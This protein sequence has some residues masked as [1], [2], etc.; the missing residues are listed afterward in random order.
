MQFRAVSHLVN[1]PAESLDQ[2]LSA[3]MLKDQFRLR[4]QRQQLD[5]DASGGKDVT[6]RLE[7]WESQLQKS[8]ELRAFRR[9][10]MPAIGLDTELPVAMRGDEIASVIRDHQVVVISGETG[11]GKSTQLPLICMQLGLGVGGFVGHTQPRRI[12]ARGVASRIAESVGSR[13]GETVGYKIRFGDQTSPGTL[14]KVMTDGILLAETAS[15]RFLNAYEAII[16]DEA[17][18]RS[19]NIDFLLCYIK[20]LLPQRPDLKLLITSA[21]IDTGKFAEHFTIDSGQPV[22]V[23]HVEGRT[24]PVDLE[25]RPVGIDQDGNEV[26]EDLESATISAIMD[27]AARDRGDMLVF[28]PTEQS[29]RSLAKKLRSRSL[30]RDGAR[31]TDILPL[32]ARLS[33]EQQNAIF[34]PGAARRI[35]LATNV[36]ESSITVPRIRYVV[37]QGLA[38]ISRYAPRS[39][40]QRLPIESV[41]QA[42]ADQRAGRCGRIGPGICV[43]LFAEDDFNGR[44]KFT[45]PEIRRTNLASVILQTKALRLGAIEDFPFIEAPG[46]E[47]IRDGYRTLH[48]I[49]AVDHARELTSLGKK[50]SR[51]PVDPR[52]GRMLYAAHDNGCLEEVLVIAS[53]LEVQDPRVRPAEQQAAADTAHSQFQ[54]EDSDFLAYLNLWD[55]LHQRREDLSRGKFRKACAQNFLSYMLVQQWFDVHRQLKSMCCDGRTQIRSDRENNAAI[56]Q[57]LLTGLLSG[58]AMQTDRHEYTGAGGIKFLLWPGSGLVKAQAAKKKNTRGDNQ[59]AL[60]KWVLV[61]EVVET[62]RRFGR[63]VARIDPAWIEPLAQHLVKRNYSEPHWSKKRQSAL[64]WEK[65]SLFGLPIVARRPV[66]YGN[67]DPDLSRQLLIEEGLAGNQMKKDPPFL[68]HN[69]G[70]LE[71]IQSLAAKT[72][73]REWII[74]PYRVVHFY[75]DR[76]PAEVFDG[77]ELSGALKRDPTL[78]ARLRFTIDDLLPDEDEDQ[79]VSPDEFPDQMAIGDLQL[80]VEYKF[81]PGADDDGVSV[82]VPLE[83]VAQIHDN[84]L[85][86]SVP[87]LLEQRIVAVIRSLPKA[88][89][90]NLVPAPE[91]AA[92]VAREIEFGRG[93]FWQVVAEGLSRHAGQPVTP[94]MFRRDKLDDALKLNIQVCDDKGEVI[95]QARSI[96]ELKSLLPDSA[97]HT[98]VA[99]VVDHGWHQDGLTNWAWDELPSQV[100]VRRGVADVPLF[101]TLVDKD[102]SVD[103]RLY[104]NR[105]LSR[106]MSRQGLATM[107]RLA[108]RKVIKSQVNWLPDL[109]RLAMIAS[110]L[111]GTQGSLKTALAQ[112]ISLVAFVESGRPVTTREE[113]E[114]RQKNAVERVGMATQKIAPWLTRFLENYQACDVQLESLPARFAHAENDIQ[115]QFGHLFSENFLTN[116]PWQWLEHYPRYL[117][118]IVIRLDRLSGALDKDRQQTLELGAFHDRFETRAAE[119]T[120]QGTIDPELDYFG[121]MIE[122]YRVSL[123]AQQLGTSET[124]SAKR[125]EKQWSKVG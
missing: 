48:E 112:L 120:R 85:G 45:T 49:G 27:L 36:A 56:H 41:S 34:K 46:S 66:R 20:R 124:V 94:D 15:D 22:P 106:R 100:V 73:Q 44:P 90:R 110:R 58:V 4:R 104:D 14:V 71:E 51:L 105:E 91:T 19:L 108:N 121:W 62:A 42:S 21:T 26:D 67:I 38:R 96:P 107:Y 79:R 43:R 40:V 123:F 92:A 69:R 99:A 64:A 17:H 93:S 70:V 59:P 29:I 28:L 88:I 125:L 32:Y 47:A 11:S 116:V 2:R 86:W 10:A 35:V 53:A 30:P 81:M 18:E 16:I 50:L 95:A 89:R 63:T 77:G 52:I 8:M 98:A 57:S 5:H 33:T 37:D 31:S 24:Y 114:Q 39:K 103:L 65:V 75:E 117:Q 23:I 80:P 111:P 118:A 55:W 113:F 72:R 9:A 60:P 97:H 122:E 102:E 109:D 87:G 3:A 83:G 82:R 7:Q 119:L 12:A 25:Y 74:D 61:S 76:L 78:D 1:H 6:G 84:H 54:H 68:I 101:P 13:L 115:R